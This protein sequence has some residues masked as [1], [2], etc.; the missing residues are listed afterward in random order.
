VF[1]R[2][3][4]FGRGGRMCWDNIKTDLKGLICEG[5]DWIGLVQAKDQFL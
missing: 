2:K 5:V 1:E 3:E 4:T